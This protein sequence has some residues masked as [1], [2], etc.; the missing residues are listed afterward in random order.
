MPALRIFALARPNP[1]G[2]RRLGH[3][4]RAGDLGHAQPGQ[5]AQRQRHLRLETQCRVAAGEDQPQPVVLDAGGLGRL[6]RLVDGHRHLPELGRA[7]D[8]APDPVG[9]PVPGDGGQPRAGPARHALHRPLPDRG[10]ER[11][12]GALLGQVPVAGDP[13]QRRDDL[14]PFLAERGGDGVLGHG[15]QSG[16]ISIIP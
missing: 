13:D 2:H 3:E 6:G 10:R 1:P 4:E 14:A 12:L 16:R 9:G 15:C 5:R 11:L 8:L 7:D